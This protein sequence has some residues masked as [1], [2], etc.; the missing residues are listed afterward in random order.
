VMALN[1]ARLM[2][3]RLTAAPLARAPASKHKSKKRRVQV[4]GISGHSGK[5]MGRHHATTAAD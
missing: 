2:S 5:G 4:A 3:G 1:P